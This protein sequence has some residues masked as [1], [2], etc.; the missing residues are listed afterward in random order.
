MVLYL[1]IELDSS[2]PIFTKEPSRIQRVSRGSGRSI[3]EVND[4]LDQHKQFAKMVDKFKGLGNMTGRGHNM[5]N[6]QNLSKM[7]SAIPPNIMKQM[8]G[9]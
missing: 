7:A 8:G 5:N 6:P 3:K 2:K 9:K 1:C 4:L